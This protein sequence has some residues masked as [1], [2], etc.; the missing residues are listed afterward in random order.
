VFAQQSVTGSY[1]DNAQLEK[2]KFTTRNNAQLEKLKFTT[3]A[4][5]ILIITKSHSVIT[6]I[7]GTL[8]T[9]L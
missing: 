5:T 2:L 9:A 6:V 7:I 1:A 3:T 8:T 4:A